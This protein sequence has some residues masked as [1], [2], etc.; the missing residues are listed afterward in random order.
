MSNPGPNTQSTQNL[1]PVSVAL[2]P[3][4]SPSATFMANGEQVNLISFASHAYAALIG[5]SLTVRNYA[6]GGIVTSNTGCGLWNWANGLIGAPFIFAKNYGVT[7]DV[8]KSIFSRAAAIPNNIGTVFVL[9]G[10]ND[11]H[12]VSS[13]ST[14]AQVTAAFNTMSSNYLTGVNALLKAG[15][16][17]V[18]ATI[19]PNNDYSSAT[20]AR[21][22]LL[23]QMN[24][25]IK[26][27]ASSTVFVADIFTA[28][29]DNS[30]PTLRLYKTGAVA[31]TDNTHFGNLGA[32]LAGK[33]SMAALTSAY[34][35][36]K[37]TATIYDS[38]DLCGLL[39][40]GFRSGTGGTAASKGAGSTGT[41]ADGWKTVMTG[42]ATAVLDNSTPY[43]VSANYVGPAQYG[44]TGIDEY[45]QTAT[46]T[47][48]AANDALELR[49]NWT[50]TS[51]A[52]F[53]DSTLAGDEFFFEFDVDVASPVS[54]SD[55]NAKGFVYFTVGTTPVDQA[56]AGTTYQ[57]VTANVASDLSNTPSAYTESFR[58]IIR[59]PIMRVPENINSTATI[60]VSTSLFAVFNAAGSAVV[61]IGRPR[62][63]H[64]RA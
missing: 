35:L 14:A 33:T 19:P 46:L 7:G 2:N 38:Y 41:L 62:A 30:Q 59:T 10:T 29:W 60:T 23:D 40:S 31:S 26:S 6:N 27:L 11:V 52:T 24:A 17:V 43:T 25:Y 20:D 55:I 3:D 48:S 34:T 50:F 64:R 49:N 39:Y 16:I 61:N 32:M 18:L 58:L 36:S 22:S 56:Y 37:K 47:A 63:W 13:S 51:A 53:P 9:A 21:I 28:L 8:I 44:P 12:A 57:S 54:L 45:F 5:D 4:G 1:V 15:K 42:T